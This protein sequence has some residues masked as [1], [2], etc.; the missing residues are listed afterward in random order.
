MRASRFLFKKSKK[1]SSHLWLE[2]QGKDLFVQEREK[3][4][5]VARS[6]FKLI[7]INAKKRFLKTG[8]CVL[9]LGAAPGGWTQVA[10][11]EGC[12]VVSNDLL[13]HSIPRNDVSF[14]LI[15]WIKGD[16][17]LAETQQRIL[18]AF[19]RS[20]NVVIIFVLTKLR[21]FGTGK[22]CDVVLCDAA[23][24]YSGSG[25]LD[26][27]RLIMLAEKALAISDVVLKEIGATLVMKISRGGEE[28][29]LKDAVKRKF[30]TVEFIKPG[31]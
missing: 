29:K 17:T 4:G 25:S 31:I 8:A 22:I 9:D 12:K 2:R 23:P 16:F 14:P 21:L 13:D 28:M 5:F 26:H 20:G 6:S 19:E 24:S 11:R 30:K 18:A 15:K 27:L 3:Q 7:D 10:L 1:L